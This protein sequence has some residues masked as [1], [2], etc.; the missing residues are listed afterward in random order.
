MLIGYPTHCQG[1]PF[2]KTDDAFPLCF[3][4]HYRCRP[5]PKTND[6]FPPVSDFHTISNIRVCRKCSQVLPFPGE[7]FLVIDSK[8]KNSPYLGKNIH[9][10]PLFRGNFLLPLPTLYIYPYFRKIFLSY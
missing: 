9:F 3:L 1:R 5:S 7:I 8:V 10:P 4:T 2:P 6:A